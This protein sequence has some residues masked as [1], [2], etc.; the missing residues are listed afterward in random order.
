MYFIPSILIQR[1]KKILSINMFFHVILKK[2]NTTYFL[3]AISFKYKASTAHLGP[4]ICQSHFTY[5]YVS[6]VEI[7]S[8]SGV[9]PLNTNDH[10]RKNPVPINGICS[11][12][13]KKIKIKKKLKIIIEVR[14]LS[15]FYVCKLPLLT[16][17]DKK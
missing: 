9:L 11:L 3:G 15:K 8:N 13:K 7:V 10:D 4:E 5:T 6:E 2:K 14:S 16:I 12:K 1:K 17:I